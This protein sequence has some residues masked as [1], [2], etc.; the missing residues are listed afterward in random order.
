MV[1][2]RSSP[3]QSRKAMRVTSAEFV[4][5]AT[6]PSEYPPGKLP[7][8]AIAGKSN[9]GKS[10]LINTLVSRKNMAK[11]SSQ[12]GRTQTINFFRV[13]EKISLVDLPGYG[14]AKAPLD[15]RRAWKPM[16]ESYLQTRRE[17][18]L[19]ILI[20]DARRGASPDDVTLQDWLDYHQI[21]SLIVL[22]KADKLSQL[23]RARQ[24]KNMAAIPLFRG[25]GL[26]FFSA[27][28]GEGK[29]ELWRRIAASMA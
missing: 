1:F 16:V 8:I 11:T 14:Y 5:S 10:S 27:L 4:R 13:N 9:V 3:Q 15:V 20:L 6:K 17:V 2:S 19:V 7:E 26:C 18:C 21:P 28:T 25:K 22:T 24:K 12:P 29:E 23:E